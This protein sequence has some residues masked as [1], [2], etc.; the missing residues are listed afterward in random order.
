MTQLGT[1]HAHSF[2]TDP[3]HLCFVLA[4]YHFVARMLAGAKSVLEVGCGDCTG[5]HVV[6]P[7]VGFWRG[8][9][10]N[11]AMARPNE[12]WTA[13]VLAGPVPTCAGGPWRAVYSLDVLE[14]IAPENEDRFFEN[15]NASLNPG[16]TCIIG[17]P[18]LESQPYASEESR[19]HHVNCKTEDGLR[20]TL[21]R[22]YENVFL[23]GLNDCTLHTGFG[24]L[25]HYRL[26]VCLNKIEG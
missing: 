3:K 5:A 25:C 15:I 22:H 14:H 6:K 8:L 2:A 20:K 23:F 19:K 11:P 17:M 1:M 18:S 7:V 16:G 12:V 9:D 24:P 21:K 4:R 13:D 10:A 26:A